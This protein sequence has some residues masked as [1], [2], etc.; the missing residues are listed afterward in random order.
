MVGTPLNGEAGRRRRKRS[1]GLPAVSLTL[2][3]LFAALLAGLALPRTIAAIILLPTEAPLQ[4]I[5]ED[6]RLTAEELS[7][8]ARRLDSA[9]SWSSAGRI[10]TDLA[11]VL[12]LLAEQMPPGSA[13]SLARFE[14]A[15]ALLVDGLG[16]APASAYPWMRLA[17]VRTVLKR[18]AQDVIAAVKASIWSSPHEARLVLP[19]L[20]LALTYW[21]LLSLDDLEIMRQQSRFAWTIP[22]ARPELADIA[23]RRF[24]A[25]QIRVA[26]DSADVGEF[27]RLLAAGR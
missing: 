3:L 15:E 1:I 16:R 20:D 9:A 26:L 5:R 8:L 4:S 11:L 25:A 13:E 24:A 10:R 23:R 2:A 18:P 14:A 27:D 17:Y 22:K 19:R 6:R 12:V 7:D 21:P